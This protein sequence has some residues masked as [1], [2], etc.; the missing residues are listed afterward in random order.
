MY[1]QKA[2]IFSDLDGTLLCD[3][4]NPSAETIAGIE[5]LYQNGYY[6][7]PVTARS[8][9]DILS[10]AK[11]M[12]ID[13]H[14][15]IVAGNNGS[16]IY[17]FKT[18]SW[19]RR[20]Y[21]PKEVVEKIFKDNYGYHKAK[22]HF[23]G[24]GAVYVFNR[25]DNSYYWAQV[26]K[27]RYVI[28]HEAKQ[29]DDEIAHLTIILKKGTSLNESQQFMQQLRDDFGDLVTVH[30]YTDRVVEIMPLNVN[31]G[32]AVKKI[33][34]HLEVDKN[35]KSYAFGDGY[36][37][38]SL[39]NAVDV[40]VAMQN[41]TLELLDIADDVTEFSND[42]NGVWHYIETKILKKEEIEYV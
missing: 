11:K 27:M 30:Q 8:T 9:N 25:G 21:L 15:G 20:D 7:I 28:A 5:K 14:G 31:K 12:K 41:A 1:K 10:L 36:N 33:L 32:Q 6:L 13:Q 34:S 29:I 22:V 35:T 2:I 4:H 37:D 23:F 3:N 24:D 40:G 18:N 42:Q 26:S 17:D 16:Q 38:L 39:F 19:I